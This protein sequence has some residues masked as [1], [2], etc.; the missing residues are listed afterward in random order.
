MLAGYVQILYAR[1]YIYI[2]IRPCTSESGASLCVEWEA[3]IDFHSFG[4]K[5]ELSLIADNVEFTPE[6]P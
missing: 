4:S 6:N 1:I 5:F 3:I 2:Y